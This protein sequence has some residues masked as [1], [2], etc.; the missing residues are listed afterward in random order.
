MTLPRSA[1]LDA[2]GSVS[3]LHSALGSSRRRE[4]FA[5]VADLADRFND[6]AG[7]CGHVQ[8]RLATRAFVLHPAAAADAATEEPGCLLCCKQ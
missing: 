8:L 2:L 3:A 6:G 4:F 5:E 1:L 7:P